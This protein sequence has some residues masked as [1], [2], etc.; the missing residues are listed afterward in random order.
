MNILINALGI[1]DS[2][3]I[4]VLDKTLD[5]FTKNDTNRYILV[6]HNNKAIL[7]LKIK[8]KH[9]DNF[10]FISSNFRNFFSR[11]YFENVIFRKIIKQKSI[12]LIY[13]F[14]GTSQFFI[15]VPQLIK[16][17]NL[18]FYSTKLDNFYKS[19]NKYFAWIKQIFIKRFIFKSMLK[20][21]KHIEIQSS[22]VK[23]HLSDFLNTK[24]KIFYVKSDN[25]V[26]DN[27]F[28]K[29]KQY[30]FS[31]KIKFLYIVGP[32][33]EYLHKN[34]LDFNK[35]M[36]SLDKYNINYEIN[37]TLTYQQLN[38]SE[39]WDPRLNSKTNFLG[40]IDSKKEMDDL[41]CDNTILISTSVI[42]TLGLHVIEAIKNGV[43][44][45]VPDEEYSL[46]VYG[47]QVFKYNLFNNDSLIS[48][49]MMI[50]ESESSF[51]DKILL[52]QNDL[53][54]SEMSKYRNILDVFEEA[55]KN[56]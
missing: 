10:E 56:V 24:N 12:N 8:Y 55:I 47:D 50:L 37:I 14:S 23:S 39:F 6:C 31:K 7:R 22:H 16:V 13:N 49:I 5:E 28:S 40:Y 2:G 26:S 46:S 48:V 9:Q 32:H 11:I 43:L 25:E 1:I 29:P 42:E 41:F 4:T 36:L 52:I 30:D 44:T 53:K 38:N 3:G 35:A 18:L 21:I 20:N 17:H 15:K 45:I 54:K 33:F 19:Q 51:K 27:F 34:I